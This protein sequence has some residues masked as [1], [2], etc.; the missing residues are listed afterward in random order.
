M[1]IYNIV[2]T[3]KS[4]LW[5]E[6]HK[7]DLRALSSALT[8]LMVEIHPSIKIQTITITLQILPNSDFSQY[9]F[10]TNK[11]QICD[12][13]Y[14]KRGD[15]MTRKHREIFDHFLHEF[16]HWMQSRIYKIGIKEVNYTDEDVMNNTN[17]YYRNRLE[18]DARQFVRQYLPKFRKYYTIF[19]KAYQ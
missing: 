6:D 7:I 5:I 15:S 18:V 3:E 16:R 1:N 4:K 9:H 12:E 19:S 14:I 2:A 10:K 13:P 11:I 17:A 8:M